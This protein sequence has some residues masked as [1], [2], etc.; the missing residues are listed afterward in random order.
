M[1]SPANLNLVMY[2]CT[3]AAAAL[4]DRG[5]VEMTMRCGKESRVFVRVE[6]F[7]NEMSDN[8]GYAVE[9]C[10]AIVMPV[11]GGANG[12]ANVSEYEQLISDGFLLTWDPLPLAGKFAH[13]SNHLSIKFLAK[14]SAVPLASF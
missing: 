14:T 7:Y 1:I 3:T 6:G 8:A 9:G 13:P 11:L 10:K 5:L 2:N 12:K 4:Q